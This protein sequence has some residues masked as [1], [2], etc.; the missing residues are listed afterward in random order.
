MLE[1]TSRGRTDV[2]CPPFYVCQ[3]TDI[4]WMEHFLGRLYNRSLIDEYKS[5][6]L[7]LTSIILSGLMRVLS[8]LPVP[9]STMPWSNNSTYRRTLSFSRGITKHDPFVEW[10]SVELRMSGKLVS[11]IMSTTPHA[12][13]NLSFVTNWDPTKVKPPDLSDPHP[14]LCRSTCVPMNAR[15]QR[16]C[17]YKWIEIETLFTICTNNIL[18]IDYLRLVCISSPVQTFECNLSCLSGCV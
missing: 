10:I 4:K 13:S 16:K 17:L 1:W 5:L 14:L 15:L 3:W 9:G 7:I 6:E 12:E 18:G 11:N 8:T 2:Y